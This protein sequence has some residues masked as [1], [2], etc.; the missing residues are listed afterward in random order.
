MLEEWFTRVRK[1]SED[2]HSLLAIHEASPSRTVVIERTYAKLTG[3]SL[4]QDDLFRQALRCLEQELYRAAHVMAWAG[5]MDFAEEKLGE[6]GFCRIQK[7]KN[8]P[9]ITSAEDIRDRYNDFHIVECL[10]MTG[11]I[12]KTEEKAFKGLLNKRNECAHPSDYY[13][14]LNES[15]G[16]VSEL[17]SRLESMQKRRIR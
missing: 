10:R 13:P 15:L 5:F 9:K 14:N 3:L 17:I 6:D 1:F 2:A 16:Y 4:R 12:S 11:L 7:V 8:D